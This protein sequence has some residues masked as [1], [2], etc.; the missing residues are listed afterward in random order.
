MEIRG[1]GAGLQELGLKSRQIKTCSRIGFRARRGWNIQNIPSMHILPRSWYSGV[2]SSILRFSAAAKLIGPGSCGLVL[3]L[4][5]GNTSIL[6]A[7]CVQTVQ[8][9][10]QAGVPASA[11]IR[12]SSTG[13]YVEGIESELGIPPHGPSSKTSGREIISWPVRFLNADV[14]FGPGSARQVPD[15]D[16]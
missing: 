6:A 4:C 15:T 9:L 14:L 16:V 5:S 1:S 2:E 3:K 13:T 7:S 10:R 11:L 12:S 8:S